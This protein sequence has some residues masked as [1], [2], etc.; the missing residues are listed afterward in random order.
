MNSLPKAI[1]KPGDEEARI[2]L[3]LGTD[4]GGYAIM[5]G[6]TNYGHLFSFSVVNKLTHG[7]ACAIVNPYAT[8]FFA[9][10]I[11]VQLKMEGIFLCKAPC[12]V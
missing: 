12:L 6:G 5:V 8:V 3:G 7:R 4:L 10:A 2:S 9:P 1:E 11:E